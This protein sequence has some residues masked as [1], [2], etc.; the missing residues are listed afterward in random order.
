MRGEPRRETVSEYLQKPDHHLATANCQTCHDPQRGHDFLPYPARHLEKVACESCH[1]PRQF[2]PAEQMV[3]AT[4]LDES[5]SPLVEYRGFKGEPVNLNTAYNRGYVPP[6][7]PM[8]Q[9]GKSGTA[10][11]LSP[12]NLV[13]RW[14]WAAGDSQEPLPREIL[15]QALLLNG[16]YRPEVIAALDQNH[17]GRLERGELKLDSESKRK[18]VEQLLLAA[19]VK[20][21]VIRAEVRPHKVSHGVAARGQALSDCAACH[22]PDSRLK[23]NIMLASWA[24]GANPPSWKGTT[25]FLAG[26]K[27]NS[28]G[29]WS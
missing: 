21:P 11:R 3:D 12:V 5:G 1:I 8:P 28:A 26:L 27:P 16:H 2:G 24:P 10:V 4:L 17:D 20:N 22:G 18:A 7:L 23:D 29:K 19:G 15:Q 9:S 13:S 14:Y 25:Q 6:L